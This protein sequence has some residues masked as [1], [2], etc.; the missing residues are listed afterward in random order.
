MMTIYWLM[1]VICGILILFSFPGLLWLE[2]R[3]SFGGRRIVHCPETKEE[4]PVRFNASKAA[5]TSLLGPRLV[6]LEDCGRWPEKADCAQDCIPEALAQNPQDAFAIN[7][8]GVILTGLLS[9][10]ASGALRYSPAAREWMAGA[11][12]SRLEFWE[13]V[14]ARA[15]VFFGLIGL[16]VTAYVLTWLMRH[17]ER[18]GVQ[19]GLITGI[20]VWIA[21]I[22][23]TLPEA[24]FT[25]NLRTFT[26]NSLAMLL[27]LVLQGL[28]LGLCVLPNGVKQEH[29]HHGIVENKVKH[30]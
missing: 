21:L 27:A 10:A 11:G 1:L 20:L 23:V 6:E 28:I 26:L 7:H 2:V 30:A 9:W 15:P 29:E 14:G 18:R 8:V 24:F 5:R 3:R 16:V 19:G 13:R 4:V 22:G 12:Y 25:S 17:T